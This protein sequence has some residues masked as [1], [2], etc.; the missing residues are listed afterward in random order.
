LR[1]GDVRHDD[2]E[3]RSGEVCIRLEDLVGLTTV[4]RRHYVEIFFLE[5]RCDKTK[6]SGIVVGDEHAP[7]IVRV[8]KGVVVL[9]V[10]VLLLFSNFHGATTLT[11]LH[12]KLR[13]EFD[14]SNHTRMLSESFSG[15]VESGAVVHRR[16]DEGQSQR[17]VHGLAKGQTLYRNHRLI[18]ITSNHRIK[19]A[20]RGTQKNSISRERPLHIYII[21]P[22]RGFD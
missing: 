6:N 8:R 16:P 13:G 17:Y 4:A 12:G 20:S 7:V 18:V 1:T 15:D 11:S 14:R 9:H 21:K 19:L 10:S 5:N 22:A 3:N 2:V